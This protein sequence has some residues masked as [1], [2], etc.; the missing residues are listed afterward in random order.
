MLY[1]IAVS[2]VMITIT[3][4]W[5]CSILQIHFQRQNTKASFELTK[6]LRKYGKIRDEH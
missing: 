1:Y 4:D 5:I 6:E 3:L 2:F